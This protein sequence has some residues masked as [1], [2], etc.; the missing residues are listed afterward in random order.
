MS[1][2][3]LTEARMSMEITSEQNLLARV[4][5]EQVLT[6][7]KC[8]AIVIH[9]IHVFTLLQCRLCRILHQIL[10]NAYVN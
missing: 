4:L 10:L 1:E 9:G 2:P 3:G 5:Y 7:R 8:K 6:S